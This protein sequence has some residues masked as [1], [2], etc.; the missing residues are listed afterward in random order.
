MLHKRLA[1]YLA[2]IYGDYMTTIL[3]R[4]RILISKYFSDPYVYKTKIITVVAPHLLFSDEIIGG[5]FFNIS[6]ITTTVLPAINPL[7]KQV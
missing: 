3:K 2:F 1:L 5:A 7:V 4:M 6:K